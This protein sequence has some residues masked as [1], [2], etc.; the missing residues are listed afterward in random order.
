[1]KS[2]FDNLKDYITLENPIPLSGFT[3]IGYFPYECAYI[4]GKTTDAIVSTPRTL[5]ADFEATMRENN[6]A[7][8]KVVYICLDTTNFGT[9][10]F[11]LQLK[12]CYAR[13]GLWEDVKGYGGKNLIVK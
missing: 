1:M 9:D 2:L 8:N 7:D 13:V 11:A 5:Y 10:N 12:D 3:V 6:I 4:V